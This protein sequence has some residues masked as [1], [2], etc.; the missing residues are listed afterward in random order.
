MDHRLSRQPG[1]LRRDGDPIAKALA[2]R[3]P[4]VRMPTLSLSTEDAADLIAYLEAMTFASAQPL[5]RR[6]GGHSGHGHATGHHH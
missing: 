4:T 1:A 3:Y 2:E 6:R 5:P